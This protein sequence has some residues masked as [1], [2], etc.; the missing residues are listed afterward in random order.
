[1]VNVIGV[2]LLAAYA[3][4]TLTYFDPTKIETYPKKLRVH[5]WWIWIPIVV[6]ITW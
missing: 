2:L 5:L 6:M 1:M 3:G 4:I